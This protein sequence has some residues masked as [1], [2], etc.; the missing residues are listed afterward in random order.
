MPQVAY[1]IERNKC[2]IAINDDRQELTD[3]LVTLLTNDKMLCEFR[4]NAIVMATKYT[5]D[6]IFNKAFK[7]TL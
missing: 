3:A 2:G 1:E 4:K 6:K 5:W 7:K